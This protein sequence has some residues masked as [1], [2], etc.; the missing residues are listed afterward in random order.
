MP[1]LSIEELTQLAAAALR[2]AGASDAMA[3]AAAKALV[4]AETEGLA[5]HGVSRIQLY[6]QHLR[7]GRADGHARVRIAADK[8]AACLI[9][10]GGGLAYEASALAVSEA[11]RRAL[12]FGWR[13]AG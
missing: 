11:I 3:D 1:R 10:A 13:C 12:E 9:D 6:A 4:A 7:E 8:G 5:G 2:K